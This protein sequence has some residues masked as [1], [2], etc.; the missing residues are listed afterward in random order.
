MTTFPF[1]LKKEWR[2]S[3]QTIFLVFVSLFAFGAKM[4]GTFSKENGNERTATIQEALNNVRTSTTHGL[5]LQQK[6][7]KYNKK[8]QIQL[9]PLTRSVSL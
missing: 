8:L 5:T 6:N 3:E 1:K 9:L 2:V 7:Y 4:A